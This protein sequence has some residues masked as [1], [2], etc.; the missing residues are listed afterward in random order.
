MHRQ[1]D[2]EIQFTDTGDSYI[3]LWEEQMARGET[4]SLES[5]LD[6]ETV[7][8]LRKVR[9]NKKMSP[10][11]SFKDAMELMTKQAQEEGLSDYDPRLNA[12]HGDRHGPFTRTKRFG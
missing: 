1:D 8:K 4:P 12:V 3:D 2:G 10:A 9:Q 6:P 7:E 11:M 5:V